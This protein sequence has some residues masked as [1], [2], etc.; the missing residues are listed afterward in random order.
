MILGRLKPVTGTINVF[1]H[2]PGSPE[3]NIPG[4]DVG[5]MPQE[6]ALFH[7]LT[8]NE[9]LHYYGR[10]YNIDANIIDQKVDHYTNFLNLPS[11]GRKVGQLSGGQQR[12]VSLAVTMIHEPPLLILDEPTVGV[13][14]LLRCR[15]WNYLEDL[16]KNHGTTVLITTHYTEE[17]R[18]AFRVGFI[19]SGTLLAQD[20]PERLIFK[21]NCSSLEDVFLE[22][23]LQKSQ[24]VGTHPQM[25][26]SNQ[27]IKEEDENY[28][29]DDEINNNNI[30]RNEMSISKKINDNYRKGKFKLSLKKSNNNNNNITNLTS[31]LS[32]TNLTMNT[33]ISSK[34]SSNHHRAFKHSK[35]L[36]VTNKIRNNNNNNININK[37]N[38]AAN[39]NIGVG[40]KKTTASTCSGDYFSANR[41]FALLTKNYILFKRN[42]VSIIL[43]NILP[44]LQ[45]ALY[46][47]SF[48]RNPQQIPIAVVNR[49]NRSTSLSNVSFSII[50]RKYNYNYNRKQFFVDFLFCSFS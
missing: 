48:E 38:I 24:D 49:D 35:P 14:S 19:D 46:C 5:Y 9:V 1:G 47:F 3:S 32:V 2:E 33:S 12:R 27:I 23:C 21:Y 13:D 8:I 45:I 36:R 39:N 37:Q 41:M 4:L 28:D 7:L 17:A 44:I 22:L 29:E 18:D 10:I 16:C 50:V 11:K 6:L 26:I 25:S 31:V 15:I 43:L 34:S 42:P 40:G 20:N 30:S